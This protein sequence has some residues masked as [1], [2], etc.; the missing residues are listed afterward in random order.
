[1]F[2]TNVTS[3]LLPTNADVKN[4]WNVISTF[5]HNVN[6]VMK[7]Q[8]D[9]LMQI[10]NFVC[11]LMVCYNLLVLEAGAAC[12]MKYQ[13]KNMV[14]SLLA[15]WSWETVCLCW[16]KQGQLPKCWLLSKTYKTEKIQCFFFCSN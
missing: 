5:I 12:V 15:V 3:S 9:K 2:V 14:F 8:N 10:L 6:V 11:C 13:N 4:V 7:H 1:L 16:V